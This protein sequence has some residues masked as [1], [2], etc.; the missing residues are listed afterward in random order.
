MV[1]GTVF[2]WGILLSNDVDD[3]DNGLDVLHL[4]LI[5]E[6]MLLGWGVNEFCRH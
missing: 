1:V 6:K 2:G 5:S 4:L 3:G